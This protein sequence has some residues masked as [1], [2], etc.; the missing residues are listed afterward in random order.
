VP[1]AVLVC[2]LNGF[3]QIN[4]RYGHLE[5][6][7]VLRDVSEALRCHCRK[8]DSVARM[9]G[10]EFVLLLSGQDPNTIESRLGE[11]KDAVRQA[12]SSPEFPQQVSISI[13]AAFYPVD[14]TEADVLLEEADRRMYAAKQADKL[15]GAPLP[16]MEAPPS[17]GLVTIQ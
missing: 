3:K 1:L 2:D 16:P 9:G 5:G 11:L 7:R 17:L 4:D 12:A 10:D 15:A 8:Y 14:G 13:G 6:N